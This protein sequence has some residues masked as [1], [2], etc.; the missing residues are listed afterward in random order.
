MRILIVYGTTEGQTRK[1]SGRAAE[2][3]RASGLDVQ[4][5]DVSELQTDFDIFPFDAV[6]VAASV[7][8]WQHQTD[9]VDFVIRHK[10]WLDGKPSAFISVSLSAAFEEDKPEAQLYVDQ[11]IDETGWQPTATLSLAGALRYREYDFMRKW[12]MRF[13]A[14][15]KSAPTDTS[16]DHEYTD[17]DELTGFLDRFV[18]MVQ[19]ADTTSA[20]QADP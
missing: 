9:M 1:I 10:S 8:Q 18:K 15:A 14:S 16:R 5:V 2:H 12:L 19:E 13:M 20:E 4:L 7:H 17:W 11:F 6:I 3:L